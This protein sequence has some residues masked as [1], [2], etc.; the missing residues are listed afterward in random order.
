MSFT[1]RG[2]ALT[3]EV[4]DDVALHAGQGHQGVE[5]ILHFT[6]ISS[7]LAKQQVSNTDRFG[8]SKRLSAV[9]GARFETAYRAKKLTIFDQIRGSISRF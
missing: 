4:D 9:S 7:G 8:D 5:G 2:G 3:V 1:L 6:F